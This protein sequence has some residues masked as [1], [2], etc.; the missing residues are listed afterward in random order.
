[1]NSVPLFPLN[2]VLFPEGLLPL[3]I[4]E[5]R[6]LDMVSESLRNQSAFGICLIAKGSE[7]G[8]PAQCREI[9][10]FAHIIDWDKGNDGLLGITV[11]GGKRFRV[12]NTRVRKNK[13]MEGDVEIIDDN[14]DEELPV[15]YQVL[16]D[17][18]RQIGDK[19][20]LSY[21]SEHE[22]YLDANWVGCRLAELLPFDLDEK[23][24]L[25]EL[26]DPLQRLEDIQTMLQG[27]TV[28]Q[29]NN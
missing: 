8:E 19:F 13:L 9:G 25:L 16:S 18:L 17:L 21:L 7:V 22:K 5:T 27:F 2:T 12:L 10:T 24:M 1:M 6:Y 29:L 23:Q 26:D 4:F 11:Q 3:R 28:E 14:E 20:K 15:E